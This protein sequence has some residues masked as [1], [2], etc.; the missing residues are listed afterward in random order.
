MDRALQKLRYRLEGSTI[1]SS[2]ADKHP[3]PSEDARAM[4]IMP[5]VG[6]S[7]AILREDGQPPVLYH[8][9]TPFADA[10]RCDEIAEGYLIG[11]LE[12]EHPGVIWAEIL[13]DQAVTA[14]QK[15][16]GLPE[17]ENPFG[18]EYWAC[19][20]YHCESG[21]FLLVADPEFLETP[22]LVAQLTTAFGLVPGEFDVEIMPERGRRF[23]AE[24]GLKPGEGYIDYDPAQAKIT[25]R[26]YDD[27]DGGE[28]A[29]E[30]VPPKPSLH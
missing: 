5:S 10:V 23:Y 25:V 27:E 29:A 18:D 16:E 21:R 7:I 19:V 24:V 28:E 1:L 11:A 30:D 26:R 15:A 6:S 3:S 9:I 4:H 20:W 13:R 2:E 22:G 8:S 14:V 12:A 17:G